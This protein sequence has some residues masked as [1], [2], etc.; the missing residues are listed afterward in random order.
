MMKRH[1]HDGG[2]IVGDFRDG[3]EFETKTEGA[4]QQRGVSWVCEKV[5]SPPLS[6]TDSGAKGGMG[7]PHAEKR[8][9]T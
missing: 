6:L 9:H 1:C 7:R 2:T 8:D 3:G 5:R 4:A